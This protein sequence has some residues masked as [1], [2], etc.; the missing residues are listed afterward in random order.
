MNTGV[1]QKYKEYSNKIE[2]YSDIIIPVW[3]DLKKMGLVTLNH[4]DNEMTLLYRYSPFKTL[5]EQQQM[6]VDYVCEAIIDKEKP[7]HKIVV[8]GGTRYREIIIDQYDC[9]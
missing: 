6:I 4:K 8:Y 3:N 5:S 2:S 7:Q 1:Y 9:I